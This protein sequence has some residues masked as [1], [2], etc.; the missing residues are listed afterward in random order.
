[1]L[2]MALLAYL[3]VAFFIGW[4]ILMA[5]HGKFTLLIASAACYLLA[6]GF[7]GCLPAKQHDQD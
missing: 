3:L 1:M 2:L 4:G 6:L 5:V 7:I